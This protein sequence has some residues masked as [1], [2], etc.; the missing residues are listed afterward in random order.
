MS[1]CLA[2]SLPLSHVRLLSTQRDKQTGR[3]AKQPA[4]AAA[5]VHR[6]AAPAAQRDRRTAAADRQVLAHDH[7]VRRLT[8]LGSHLC[9]FLSPSSCTSARPLF[10][11]P[12]P[13]PPPPVPRQTQRD[14]ERVNTH[15]HTETHT[16]TDMHT[17]TARDR[18]SHSQSA[19]TV[20]GVEWSGKPYTERES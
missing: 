18:Q 14:S 5:H 15:T 9:S 2:P 17:Q 20:S 3:P 19:H 1:P 16:E 4:T 13:L 7:C 8:F 6:P 10:P 12:A 11:F